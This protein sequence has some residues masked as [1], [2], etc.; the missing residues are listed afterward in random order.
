MDIGLRN[1]RDSGPFLQPLQKPFRRACE[2]RIV[3]AAQANRKGAIDGKP[4][5]SR[6]H[7][8]RHRHQVELRPRRSSGLGQ[9]DRDAD[10]EVKQISGFSR[11]HAINNKRRKTK[12]P[13]IPLLNMWGRLSGAVPPERSED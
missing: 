2:N 1:D 10:R 6:D 5:V 13:R 7:V 9:Q 4:S 8:F 3:P 12:T 11:S